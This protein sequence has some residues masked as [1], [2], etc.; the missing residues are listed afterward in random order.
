MS[1]SQSSYGV[2]EDN[3]SVTIIILLSQPSS[4][5]FEVEIS[6][7]EFTAAGIV[8]VNYVRKFKSISIGVICRQRGL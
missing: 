4:V 8:F 1:F 2:M 5:Q 7:V 3:G 6:T